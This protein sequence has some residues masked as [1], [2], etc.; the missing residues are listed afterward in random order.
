MGNKRK[1]G[2]RR[3]VFKVKKNVGKPLD[4]LPES[5]PTPNSTQKPRPSPKITPNAPSSSKVKLG[6]NKSFY[7]SK[8]EDF[9]YDIIDVS[10]FEANL[11]DIAVC[12]KCR[13]SL[14]LRRKPLEGLVSQITIFSKHCDSEKSFSN[15][16][17]VSLGI[18]D[19][20]NLQTYYDL[21]LR[22]VYGLRVIGKGYTSA[23]SLCGIMNL[24]APPT[25]FH[26]HEAL[27]GKKAEVLCNKSMK[28]AVEEAVLENEGERD[29]SVAVDGSWQKRGHT[30][31]N[32]I[33]SV[34]SLD[35]CKVLDIYVM[36]K[37]CLC[38]NR[39]NNEHI[40]SCKANYQGSS[41][42]ME[43]H[44]ALQLFNRSVPRY[45]VK[46]LEYLGD[47]DTN[48]FQAVKDSKPY[49]EDN[50][51]TKIECVGHVQKRMG[52]R[53]RKLKGKTKG[54]LADGK[55]LSGKNRLT[56]VA[57]QKLQTFYGLAIRRHPND[58]EGM[59][60][61][62]W[63]LY[64][65]VMSTDEKPTHQLCPKD[66][67]TWCKYNKAKLTKEA[68]DHT[69]HFH[70]PEIIMLEIKPIFKALA[71]PEVLKK[72]LKGKSQNPNESL[73]NL[74][75]S[76]IPKRTFVGLDTLNF[77]VYE[78]VLSFNE[79]YVS[80]LKMMEEL[81]LKI[82]SRLVTAMKKLDAERVRKAEKSASD[83]ER[84]CAK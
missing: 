72:C 1:S 28:A 11:A 38:P 48:A 31:L 83:F 40:V 18:N 69:K 78:A 9:G 52:T 27:L 37:Y 46:Y 13:G 47:G 74:I 61:A 62:V 82:G 45:Q 76:R 15:C 71:N 80:K 67:L 10:T 34:T 39:S 75:W 20:D 36:S 79:G 73:N 8:K 51:I 84:K 60:K 68:Y 30:S 66:E 4:N 43:V 32:G 64:F 25:K 23:R 7:D 54:K 50:E 6:P 12:K 35:N 77:G 16:E 53:L 33:L 81:G 22:L 19:E 63:A 3:R 26:K 24:P 65:H 14:S 59:K 55:P 57:V 58:L 21:N 29:I 42:G 49:G 2:T 70:L 56:N 17:K 41:G 5:R 44:G